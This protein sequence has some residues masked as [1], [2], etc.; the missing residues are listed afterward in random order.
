MSLLLSMYIDINPESEAN[1]KPMYAEYPE[2][3]QYLA[4]TCADIDMLIMHQYS[5]EFLSTHFP[6][7][8]VALESPHHHLQRS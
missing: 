6:F 3:T 1:E 7:N 5:L 2:L 4:S 8:L